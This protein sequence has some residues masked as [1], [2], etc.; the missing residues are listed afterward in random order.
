M[1]MT[2]KATQNI[3]NWRIYKV[4]YEH[5]KTNEQHIVLVEAPDSWTA[6]ES[7]IGALGEE[8]DLLQSRS[9]K[10]SELN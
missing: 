1:E 10:P 2:M 3:N 8:Y 9:V 6:G 4:V 7:V 5:T